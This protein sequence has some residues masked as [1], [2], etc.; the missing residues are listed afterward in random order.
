[1]SLYAKRAPWPYHIHISGRGFL[2]GS[3]RPGTPAMI[4]TKAADIAQV[5]PPD[6]SYASTSPL[7]D[8]EEPYESLVFGL[9]QNIQEKWQDQRYLSA[10]GVDLS[11]W[12]WCKG[13]EVV[14]VTPGTRDATVGVTEFFELGTTLYCANGRYV[15]QKGVGT[16]VWTIAKDFGAGE[17][18]LD[19]QVF[20]SNFDGVQH[21]FFALQ[22]GVAQWTTNGT[23]YTAMATFHARAFAVTGSEFWWADDVNQLRKCD[24]N[25]DPTNE[26]NYTNLIFRV[27]DKSAFITAL[28]ITAGGVLVIAKTDGLYTLNAAGE[29]Q[30]LFP[31]LRYAEL[32]SNGKA[33]GQF[34]NNLFV[35]YG[36]SLG[37]LDP[38]LGW[39]PV[40][41]DTLINNTSEVRGRVSAFAGVET[42]Y[43]WAGV[44]DPDTS[45]S[46]LCK[47][48]AWASQDTPETT[49]SVHVDAWHGAL[50][51]PFVGKAI[52]ALFVSG[53]DAPSAHSRTYI[54]FS[55]G[56]I[57]RLINSCTPNPAACA[58]YR[59][60]VG[61]H[62][63]DL[64]VWHGG[65]HASVK[66]LRS[67]S[68]T[69]PRLSAAD[70]VTLE[71]AI[72]N[73]ALQSF[74]Y[75]FDGPQ[76]Y[77]K[78][79]FPITTAGTLVA[80]RVHLHN[81]SATSTPLV[82]AV[83]I[84]HALRP[85]RLMQFECDILCADG[86]VR[87]DGVPMRMGRTMIRQL[88][89][90]AV[91]TY[92]AVDVVLPDETVQKL[93]FTDYSVLQSFDEIGRQWRGSLRVKAVQW[94]TDAA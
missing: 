72:D 7:H 94:F 24:T 44:L 81:T 35:S 70:H 82:S 92:G 78:H 51:G 79:E 87:R 80:F 14:Q 28:M 18:I 57:G 48:G 11:V 66:S 88:I 77:E 60:G 22:N 49:P 21:A 42:Q 3:P 9:G 83:A 73:G 76:T 58:R 50:A 41:L 56:S 46:F 59:Y 37:K 91:D 62:Y 39:T 36:Y 31:F 5:Q 47:F 19:V 54:G 33:W 29:D 45:T 2:I 53:I 71:Y 26:A 52:Q 8:R 84:G 65:Y 27:G 6:F 23:V 25:A 10:R 4:S 74:G 68:V 16:D 89:E 64:A 34:E 1:M 38:G 69:A 43:A 75:A 90:Q 61:D 17:A 55:D 15:L 86:L 67:F 13:P 30:E 32:P 40:G 93:S 12:P 20:T 63:V 85:P